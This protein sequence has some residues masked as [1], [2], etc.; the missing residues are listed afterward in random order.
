MCEGQACPE[1]RPYRRGRTLLFEIGPMADIAH[2]KVLPFGS[3]S[4]YRAVGRVAAAST[5][6]ASAVRASQTALPAQAPVMRDASFLLTVV[7]AL[8]ALAQCARAKFAEPTLAEPT[9]MGQL[10]K[11]IDPF[12]KLV[13]GTGF[14]PVTFGL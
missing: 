8:W 12:E 11:A 6:D 2:S 1:T 13:A 7:A 9:K 14:E 4:L 3:V 5:S 10:R